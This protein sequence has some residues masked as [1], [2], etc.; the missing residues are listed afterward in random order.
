MSNAS[1]PLDTRALV[2]AASVAVVVIA[3][4]TLWF[5]L[6]DRRFI[7]LYEHLGATPFDRSTASRYWMA[8]LVASGIVLIGY[9]AVGLVLRA[10]WQGYAPPDWR[11]IWGYALL[12]IAPLLLVVLLAFGTPSL[13]LL[14]ALIVLLVLAA[15]LSLALYAATEIVLSPKTALWAWVDGFA[16]GPVLLLLPLLVEFAFRRETTT[17]LFFAPL[18]PIAGLAW[19]GVMT[20]IYRRFG[21]PYPATSVVMLAG[22]VSAYLLLPVVHYLIS[23]PGYIRYISNSGNFFAGRLWLQIVTLFVAAAVVWGA[24]MLR[25][26]NDGRRVASLLLIACGVA[27]LVSWGMSPFT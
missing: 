2:G 7:F 21:Q 15:G 5:V 9:A 10:A 3:L 27:A 8:G 25:G 4:F 1:K 14:L 13:P 23:R 20:F 6:L 19:L 22:Y 17:V 16:L 11:R 26:S 12:A 18:L 24:G